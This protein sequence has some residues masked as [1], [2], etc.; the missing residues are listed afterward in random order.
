MLNFDGLAG[1]L[2]EVQQYK[3]K[4]LDEL[5]SFCNE[6][7]IN[8]SVTDELLVGILNSRPLNEYIHSI[9]VVMT[10]CN[11]ILYLKSIKEKGLPSYR[12][13]EN[14]YNNK[15]YPY[16]SS[17]YIST[18]TLSTNLI[19]S[20][21]LNNGIYITIKILKPASIRSGITINHFKNISNFERRVKFIDKFLPN[22]F[23][24]ITTPILSK[25]QNKIISNIDYYLLKEKYCKGY[26][27]R[28]KRD[29]YRIRLDKSRVESALDCSI[30]RYKFK[31]FTGFYSIGINLSPLICL[32]EYKPKSARKYIEST[33]ISFDEFYKEI[34]KQPRARLFWCSLL[35][36]FYLR[37][38][39]RV[40]RSKYSQNKYLREFAFNFYLLKLGKLYSNKISYIKEL[41]KYKDIYHL[42][43]ELYEYSNFFDYFYKYGKVMIVN[44]DLMESYLY[45]LRL[46]GKFAYADHILS[47]LSYRKKLGRLV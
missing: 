42:E 24:K 21:Y 27:F 20:P 46:Q 40:E 47:K 17:R 26:T 37:R 10:P 16:S 22:S 29:K 15:R 38:I 32:L 34:A 14:I 3:L 44:R 39:K 4:L 7:G 12:T 18:D 45:L 43:S 2:N 28:L 35:D 8:Y 23:K 6:N 30:G 41:V 33:M 1:D 25:V 9:S 19:A 11:Y 13:I 5:N 31:L 36:R